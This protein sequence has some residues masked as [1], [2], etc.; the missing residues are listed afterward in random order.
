MPHKHNAD[1]RHPVPKMSFK[2]QNW[3]E[4][5]AGLRRRGRLTLWIED[6]ALECW[7]TCGP[8]GPARYT[9]A[10][11][12]TS[13]ML[14]TAFKRPLRQTEGLMASVLTLLDLTI[15]APDH[16]MVSRRAV[17]LPV[18]QP[19]S[20]PPGPLHVD[21]QHRPAGLRGRPMAGGEAW[22]EVAPDLQ[23]A[24][25]PAPPGDRLRRWRKLHRAVDAAS[26]MIVAQTLTDQD[27]DDASQV[28]P[29]L[30][31]IDDPIARVTADGAYDGV[32]GSQTIAAHGGG[33]DVVVPPR[34][35]AVARGNRA[36][37]SATAIWR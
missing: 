22:R 21:R 3:P 28:G 12:Q 33:I 27:T 32:P 11:L 25:R 35:T 20:V 30:D 16:A 9:N 29:L 8:G 14:R 1:R 31:R 36:R 4:Y 18:I 15:S 26:G 37:H 10:A 6:V 17:T 19:A 23:P 24:S 13:L 2:A 7:Q 34:S 5:E